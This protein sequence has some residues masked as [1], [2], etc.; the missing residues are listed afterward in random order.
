[1]EGGNSRLNKK[2]YQAPKK[3]PEKLETRH[4]C[5]C[6]R[7]FK[8]KKQYHYHK[9]WECGKA[10]ECSR[11]HK[12]MSTVASLRSHEKLCTLKYKP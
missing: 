11:C 6:N 4:I 10:L 1:M 3:L 8:H 7:S 2:D 12:L 9:R 5:C